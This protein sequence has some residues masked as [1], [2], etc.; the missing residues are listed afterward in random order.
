MPLEVGVSIG[1]SAAV[2]GELVAVLLREGFILDGDEVLVVLVQDQDIQVALLSVD[3]VLPLLTDLGG[4]PIR[5]EQPWRSHC[6]VEQGGDELLSLPVVGRWVQKP[7]D[8][9]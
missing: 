3:D 1:Q 5:V 7:A 2:A 6:G 9:P 4:A 8:D